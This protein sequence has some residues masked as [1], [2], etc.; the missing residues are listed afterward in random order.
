MIA[1]LLQSLQEEYKKK[2]SEAYEVMKSLLK[3]QV[4]LVY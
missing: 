2:V 3:E 4:S 1:S